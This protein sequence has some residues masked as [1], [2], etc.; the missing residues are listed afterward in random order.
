MLLFCE[1]CPCCHIAHADITFKACHVAT[2]PML[3][4]CHE[5]ACIAKPAAAAQSRGSIALGFAVW[6][7]SWT[8]SCQASV[9]TCEQDQA[10]RPD[11]TSAAGR[12][13]RAE[14]S[15]HFTC[16]WWQGSVLPHPLF[17]RDGRMAGIDVGIDVGAEEDPGRA[18]PL[19]LAAHGLRGR[20]LLSC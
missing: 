16:A 2:R 17:F 20:F 3:C 11:L 6:P 14:Q 18:E 10:D 4:H 13:L 8:V 19:G 7:C 5:L 9:V 15:N 1:A 12:V